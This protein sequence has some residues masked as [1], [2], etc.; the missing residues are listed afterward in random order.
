MCFLLH[1]MLWSQMV[2]LAKNY[3]DQGAYEKA[4]PLYK[5]LVAQN[6]FQPEYIIGLAKTHQ[7]LE[8]YI[9]AE[10]LLQ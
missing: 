10:L 7:Q 8:D 1:G 3:F 6:P 5:K 4:L 2:D 9:A